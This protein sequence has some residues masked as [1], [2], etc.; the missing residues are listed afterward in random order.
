MMNEFKTMYTNELV[1]LTWLITEFLKLELAKK[2]HSSEMKNELVYHLVHEAVEELLYKV[3]P[4]ITDATPEMFNKLV[5]MIA[6][7]YDE[8]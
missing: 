7:K 1:S 3:M 2:G 6:G 5:P 4:M 8:H